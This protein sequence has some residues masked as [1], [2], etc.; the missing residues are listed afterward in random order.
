MRHQLRAKARSMDLV[1][2]NLRYIHATGFSQWLMTRQNE[3]RIHSALIWSK[4]PS[5][6]MG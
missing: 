5:S 3:R 2:T 6:T 4:I 1:G